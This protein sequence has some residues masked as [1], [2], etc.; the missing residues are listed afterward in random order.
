MLIE[1]LN[2]LVGRIGRTRRPQARKPSGVMGRILC[3]RLYYPRLLRFGTSDNTFTYTSTKSRPHTRAY[4]HFSARLQL[5]T[6]PSTASTHSTTA[7]NVSFFPSTNVTGRPLLTSG[8][9]SD[10]LS[11]VATPLMSLKAGR[12]VLV[13]STYDPGLEGAFRVVVYSSAVGV[14]VRGPL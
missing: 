3:M 9:Y 14:E 7:L 11:G 8:P 2:F 1:C 5:S 6:S 4:V 13:P 12:Y 10:A